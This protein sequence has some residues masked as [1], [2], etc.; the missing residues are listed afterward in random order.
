MTEQLQAL[1]A[2]H[3]RVLVVYK[4]SSRPVPGWSRGR[5]ADPLVR[6][7]RRR[8]L[9]AR[10]A[11]RQA[12]GQVLSALRAS[13]LRARVTQRARS[14]DTRPY[15]LVIAVGGDGTFLEAARCVAGAGQRILGVNSDPERSAGSFC[16]TDGAA[17]AGKLRQILRGRAKTARLNR[18]ELRLNGRRLGAPVL[19]DILVTH[20]R[21]AAMS[22]Y[23]LRVG[24]A[25]EE[26]RSSGLWI[27]TAAGSTGAIRSAGGKPLARNSRALVYRPRELYSGSRCRLRGGAV[28]AGRRVAVGSLMR[29]GMICVDGEHMTYPFR[30]G[31]VLE[32]RPSARP[33]RV[34]A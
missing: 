24:A 2:P 12:M 3:R 25:R 21:P 32:V 33:L 14:L 9:L 8:F 31:D 5:A 19:N 7:D 18:M 13:G 29:E 1:T 11:H 30:Y 26:Q 23:W 16:S 20:R 17:F 4:K 34:V 27:A 28:P 22:R 15:P 10:R 6:R